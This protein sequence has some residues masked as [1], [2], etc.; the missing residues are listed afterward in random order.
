MA[1]LAR[2]I[3]QLSLANGRGRRFFIAALK[4]GSGP[5]ESNIP[6]VVADGYTYFPH[7]WLAKT[8]PRLGESFAR[9]AAALLQQLGEDAMKGVDS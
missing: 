5:I 4:Q 8:Y 2:T 6:F 1:D 9:I 3:V 7:D